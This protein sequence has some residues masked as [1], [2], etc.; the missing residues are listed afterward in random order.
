MALGLRLLSV[1]QTLLVEAREAAQNSSAQSHP[2]TEQNFWQYFRN[3][4]NKIS[5]PSNAQATL[6][7]N[8]KPR[9]Q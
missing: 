1:N 7:A 4:T 6:P 5:K 8:K 3:A 2:N 9:M